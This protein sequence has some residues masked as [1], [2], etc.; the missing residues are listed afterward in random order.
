MV[1]RPLRHGYTYDTRGDGTT[2]VKRYRGPD[3]DIRRGTEVA[4][5]PD[6]HSCPDRVTGHRVAPLHRPPDVWNP[7]D[8]ARAGRVFRRGSAQSGRPVTAYRPA[9]LK[10][11][12][13]TRSL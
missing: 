2:V 5:Q 7:M 9:P 3:A 8:G 6:R 10:T 4:R 12:A 1:M 13:V 11:T